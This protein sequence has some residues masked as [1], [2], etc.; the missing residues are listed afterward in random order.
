MPP[1]KKSGLDLLIAVGKKKPDMEGE[2]PMMGEPEMEG[3]ENMLTLPKG[4]KPPHEAMDG[5]PFTTS[6]R[7]KIMDGKFMVEA[8]GDMPLHKEQG[9]TPAEEESESPEEEAQED[10]I[11]MEEPSDLDKQMD[12]Q[13]KRRS[14]EASK[15]RNV[16]QGRP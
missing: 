14:M 3:M 5:E 15:A 10:E 12:M 11:P 2:A 13:A 7:G 16:F 9:E 4:F 8:I 1:D 6:I